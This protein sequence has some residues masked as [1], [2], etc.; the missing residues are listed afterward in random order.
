VPIKVADYIL[1]SGVGGLDGCDSSQI[2]PVGTVAHETGHGFGLPDLYDTD[3]TSEGVGEYSLMGSGNYT[4]P[5]SPTRMDAWSL[6]ELGWVTIV[7]L[8]NGGTFS[9]GAAPT[10]DTAFYLPVGAPTHAASTSCWKIASRYSPTARCFTTTAKCGST[11]AR[12][13]RAA[14]AF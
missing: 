2:M 13:P 9:F 7:P 11:P 8:R 6:N 12:R 1:E 10:S 5:F 3:G 4:S 14:V